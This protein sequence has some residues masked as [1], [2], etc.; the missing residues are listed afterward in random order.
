MLAVLLALALQQPAATVIDRIVAVVG[1]DPIM[2][3]DVTAATEFHLVQP[4][5][6]T[7]DPTA[8]V[9][10]QLIRR[11]LMLEEVDRFQPPMP[12]ESEITVRVN[13]LE[14]RAGSAAA[15]QRALEVTGMTRD[16]LRHYI[17]DDLRIR[18][19][20]L[21]RFGANRPPSEFNAA[22]DAWVAD[23]RRRTQITVLYQGS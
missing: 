4:P 9:L 22:I 14:Q 5:A 10:D 11:A 1:S 8:Y 3:S 23:L 13:E 12:A 21:Q 18:T 17:R 16:Q 15:F 20:L 7:A 6:G 19:Y 2:L